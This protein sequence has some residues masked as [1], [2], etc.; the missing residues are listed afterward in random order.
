MNKY[1]YIVVASFRGLNT[2]AI[3]N[4]CETDDEAIKKMEEIER[5]KENAKFDS[6]Y[7]QIEKMVIYK[8]ESIII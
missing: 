5:Y 1:N 6:S 7:R 8:I 4:Y 2:D 3:I